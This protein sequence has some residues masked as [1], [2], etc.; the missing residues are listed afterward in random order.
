[1]DKIDIS[2][3]VDDSTQL[4]QSEI[5]EAS[6][7]AAVIEFDDEDDEGNETAFKEVVRV[8]REPDT[9]RYLP[10]FAFIKVKTYE[11][12]PSNED[13]ELSFQIGGIAKLDLSKYVN[14][15]DEPVSFM[16]RPT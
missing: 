11:I 4:R 14:T 9:R 13:K 10:K 7:A 2:K 12:D 1:M 6:N 5:S 16:F 8:F 3:Y 15:K